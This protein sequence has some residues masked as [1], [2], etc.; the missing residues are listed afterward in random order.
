MIPG[1]YAVLTVA[2]TGTGLDAST[3]ARL[4][5][6]FFTTKEVGKGTGL[7]L[8]TVFGIVKQAGGGITVDSTLG[9]G[10][11]FKLYFPRATR[12]SGSQFPA[13][14]PPEAQ[15]GHEKLLLVE[16]DDA[17]RAVI[18]RVLVARGYDVV[19]VCAPHLAL[20]AFRAHG[21]FFD[22]V[23]TDL[24]MPEMNGRSMVALMRGVHA[25][26]KV[27]F[28]SGYTERTAAARGSVRPGDL[29]IQ[30]PFTAQEIAAAVRHALDQAGAKAP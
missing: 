13:V 10:T 30:K 12:S 7:G 18:R 19:D 25:D 28:M 5:E 3:R 21:R 27:L 26:V 23:I 2:D 9:R 29:F 20:D 14:R 6:P 17:L 22:L 8:S 15:G 24:V 11:T 16:D 1:A 4:F